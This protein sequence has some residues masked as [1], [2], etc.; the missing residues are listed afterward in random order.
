MNLDELKATA[1]AA[2]SGAATEYAQYEYSEFI[3][4]ANPEAILA[5]ITRLEAL[6]QVS[7]A[8]CHDTGHLEDAQAWDAG[9]D[10]SEC[11]YCPEKIDEMRALLEAA[12]R[13]V[14]D[15]KSSEW[16][17]SDRFRESLVA[18]DAVKAQ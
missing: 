11:P 17:R 15:V 12:E 1:Q 3:A 2:I 5:L 14:D 16:R 8:I 10:N 18:Y 6:E 7:C 4:L 13:V 9:Q